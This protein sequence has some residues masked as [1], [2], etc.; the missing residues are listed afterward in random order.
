MEHT[1]KQ[2]FSYLWNSLPQDERMRLMPH[3]I[4]SQILHIQ[5]CRAMAIASHKEHMNRL[6]DWLSN[7][8]KELNK[9]DPL[10]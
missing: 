2:K 5:Q 6:N 8:E 1:A 9:I 7:L 3:A 4:E 10:K